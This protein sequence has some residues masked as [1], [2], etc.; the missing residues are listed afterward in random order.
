MSSREKLLL[1]L[2]DCYNA[3]DEPVPFECGTPNS[4]F[5]STFCSRPVQALKS[6]IS[7]SLHVKDLNPYIHTFLSK[8][9][10]PSNMNKLGKSEVHEEFRHHWEELYLDIIKL[11][12]LKGCQLDQTVEGNFCHSNISLIDFK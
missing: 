12:E 5:E 10:L 3:I 2:Q 11:D 1:A 9:K 4:I 7:I 6:S 8:M